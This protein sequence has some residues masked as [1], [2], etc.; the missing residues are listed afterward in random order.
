MHPKQ[1]FIE[2]L[3]KESQCSLE[4][5]ER[6]A[7][8]DRTAF[9]L[10]MSFTESRYNFLDDLIAATGGQQVTCTK[11]YSAFGWKERI[12]DCSPL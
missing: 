7:W 4:E 2:W 3:A 8:E 1:P 12:R 10:P 9:L 5:A 11:L 6:L